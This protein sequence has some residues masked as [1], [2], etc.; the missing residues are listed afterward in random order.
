MG[1]FGVPESSLGDSYPPLVTADPGDIIYIR[2]IYIYIYHLCIGME[3]R[4]SF[5]CVDDNAQVESD[6]YTN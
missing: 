3:V 6:K 2:N 4:I 5:H 1:A